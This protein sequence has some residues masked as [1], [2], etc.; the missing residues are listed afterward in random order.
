VAEQRER[1]AVAHDRVEAAGEVLEGASDLGGRRLVDTPSAARQLER[2]ELDVARQARWP[3]A[4]HRRAAARVGE[5]D[6]VDPRP[7]R[8]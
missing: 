8:A 6:E 7:R 5:A 1:P 4:E 2:P 3:A